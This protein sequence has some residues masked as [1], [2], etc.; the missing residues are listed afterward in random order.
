VTSLAV[1][2]LLAAAFLPPRDAPTLLTSPAGS[3]AGTAPL[4]L[5]WRPSPPADYYLVELHAGGRLAHATSV[6]GTTLVVP[7]WLRPGRYAWQ[8][9]AGDGRPAD[10]RVRGPVERGWIVVRDDAGVDQSS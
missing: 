4:S 9:F 1:A 6:P 10:R 7:G 5:S 8:V 3:A 2:G